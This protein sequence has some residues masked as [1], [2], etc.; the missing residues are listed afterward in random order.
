[1]IVIQIV[2][3]FQLHSEDTNVML[4]DDVLKYISYKVTQRKKCT[5]GCLSVSL[6]EWQTLW[7]IRPFCLVQ[8]DYKLTE[9]ELVALTG[10]AAEATA[11]AAA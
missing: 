8:K 5:G 4:K 7:P 1:M 3:S 10:T 6:A 9:I 11:V 2:R